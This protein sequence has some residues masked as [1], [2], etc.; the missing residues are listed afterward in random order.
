MGILPSVQ[1]Y[2]VDMPDT[3]EFECAK[4][5]CSWSIGSL[6]AQLQSQDHSDHLVFS[7]RND[8]TEEVYQVE[9]LCCLQWMPEL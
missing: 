1:L 6:A 3:L 4:S 7:N 8:P 9:A 5:Q 2:T